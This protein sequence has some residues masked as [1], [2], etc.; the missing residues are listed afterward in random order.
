MFSLYQFNPDLNPNK[1][2][3]GE[4]TDFIILFETIPKSIIVYQQ[5]EHRFP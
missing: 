1:K 3:A 5:E 4:P 2:S